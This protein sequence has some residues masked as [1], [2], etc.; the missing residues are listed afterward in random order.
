MAACK[1][2]RRRARLVHVC[3]VRRGR[4]I[5]LRPLVADDLSTRSPSRVAV[6]ARALGFRLARGRQRRKRR[7]CGREVWG[8]KSF[9]R[10]RRDW[11]GSTGGFFPLGAFVALVAPADIRWGE[12]VRGVTGRARLG[13]RATTAGFL[14]RA[15]RAGTLELA[16]WTGVTRHVWPFWLVGVNCKEPSWGSRE[17]WVKGAGLVGQ[18]STPIS[19]RTMPIWT[20]PPCSAW[21]RWRTYGFTGAGAKRSTTRSA[22]LMLRV[23]PW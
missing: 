5:P 19:A 12:P 18:A 2:I 22:A 15:V 8:E 23:S 21:I 16:A 4:T 9:L 7:H 6:I 10:G 1:K 20:L 3:T 11:L 13:A 14:Q 17:G